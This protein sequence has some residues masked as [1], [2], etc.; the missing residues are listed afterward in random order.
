M[1][2]LETEYV[3]N[4]AVPVPL[5][6][7]N[8]SASPRDGPARRAAAHLN[9]ISRV[10]TVCQTR[11]EWRCDPA[12][13]WIA[14]KVKFCTASQEVLQRRLS[15]FHKGFSLKGN[16][17]IKALFDAFEAEVEGLELEM[18]GCTGTPVSRLVLVRDS[19]RN[20]AGCKLVFDQCASDPNLTY[21]DYKYRLTVAQERNAIKV[22]PADN[23]PGGDKLVAGAGA[24]RPATPPRKGKKGETDKKGKFQKG[25]Q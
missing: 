25:T 19:L 15:T 17:T 3:D 12:A 7:L 16:Q 8:L 14:L 18:P 21:E 23:P 13:L 22:L 6:E 24:A 11:E 10:A 5:S 4:L 20:N 2:P 9:F 1:H